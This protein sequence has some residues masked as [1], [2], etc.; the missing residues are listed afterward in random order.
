MTDS[1]ESL[2]VKVNDCYF[3]V[4]TKYVSSVEE[5]IVK[6]STVDDIKYVHSMIQHRD[7]VIPV[8][9]LD[10]YMFHTNS[11]NVDNKLLVI[12]NILGINAAFE[13]DEAYTIIK[14]DTENIIPNNNILKTK[15]SIISHFLNVDNKLIGL[16][17]V[18][19]I[20]TTVLG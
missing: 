15:D 19:K 18:T 7:N 1:K 3:G 4:D 9:S 16:I 14:C 8:V 2:A 12:C 17:E 5:N 20:I 6:H 13:I 10:E 11:N